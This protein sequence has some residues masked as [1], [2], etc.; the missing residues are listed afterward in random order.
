MPE[1]QIEIKNSIPNLYCHDESI[2]LQG[3]LSSAIG[4]VLH[5][6]F[7]KC[8]QATYNGTCKTDTEIIEF[9]KGKYFII[10]Y[11][12]ITLD[13]NGYGHNTFKKKTNL[14]W[15]PINVQ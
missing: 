3:D 7:E 6:V 4:S 14:D 8:D 2:T 9:I 12:K 13:A 1:K 15:L 10:A 11:N 5:L